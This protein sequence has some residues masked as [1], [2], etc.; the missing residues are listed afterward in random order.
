MSPVEAKRRGGNEPS[1]T[2]TEASLREQFLDHISDKP[3]PQRRLEKRL[4][5]VCQRTLQEFQS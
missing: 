4:T 5:S 3:A 1:P 2:T